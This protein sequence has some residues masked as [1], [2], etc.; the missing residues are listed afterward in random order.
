MIPRAFGKT[1]SQLKEDTKKE[2][3]ELIFPQIENFMADQKHKYIM[4][5]LEIPVVDI[6]YYTEIQQIQLLDP[7][8]K[9]KKEQFPNI[10]KWMERL[11]F[12]FQA[13]VPKDQDKKKDKGASDKAMNILDKLNGNYSDILRQY[14][15]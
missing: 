8:I 14:Q 13:K 12:A 10:N 3:M 11:R 2:L 9:L 4:G 6:Q 7:S 5:D 15:F 1:V